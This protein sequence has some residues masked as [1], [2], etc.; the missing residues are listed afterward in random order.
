[1]TQDI[2]EKA[3]RQAV[4]SSSQ[5]KWR[6]PIEEIDIKLQEAKRSRN[7]SERKMLKMKFLALFKPLVFDSTNQPAGGGGS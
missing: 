5:S 2:D 7:S 6:Q 4:F 1:M 3:N